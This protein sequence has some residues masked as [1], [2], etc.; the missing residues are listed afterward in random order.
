MSA[1]SLYRFDRENL[2]IT[3]LEGGVRSGQ[4]Q[5]R[6]PEKQAV[7]LPGRGDFLEKYAPLARFLNARGYGVTSLDWPGQGGSQRLGRHPQVG[8]IASYDAYVSALHRCLTE[9]SLV[10][11]PMVWIAYSMGAPVALQALLKRSYNVSALALISPMF[12]FKGVPDP[13]AHALSRTASALGYSRHFALGERPT[14]LSTWRASES[15]V[16]SS[17][18]AFEAFKAFLMSHPD[19]LL[20][21]SSWGWVG[22]SL[23]VFK[24]LRQADLTNLRLPVLCLSAQDEQTVSTKAQERMARR[25]PNATLVR[26]PGKHDLLLNHPDAVEDLLERVAVFFGSAV[27]SGN[28]AAESASIPTL[29]AEMRGTR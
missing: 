21:G 16:S 13:L 9:A 2:D 17:P 18:Q 8:H 4:W 12:G 24:I 19:Y 15:Q 14:D 25:L 26:L 6:N 23:E 11:R 10:A 7:I 5:T 3:H 1:T 28:Q 22:A 27:S 20:G 29:S